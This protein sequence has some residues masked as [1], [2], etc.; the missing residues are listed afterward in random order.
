MTH[1]WLLVLVGVLTASCSIL[2]PLGRTVG[3]Y[4]RHTANT[5]DISPA[6]IDNNQKVDVEGGIAKLQ[7]WSDEFGS[8]L[9]GG[10]TVGVEY[11]QENGSVS[12][13]GGVCTV[14]AVGGGTDGAIRA[15]AIF[16]TSVYED[17]T[18]EADFQ[19]YDYSTTDPSAD[20]CV[21]L[22]LWV[23]TNNFAHIYMHKSS[24]SQRIYAV[25][26]VGGTYNTVG[27]IN[28]T[29]TD[30][31]F[32][33]VRSGDTISFHY[34]DGGG[35]LDSPEILVVDNDKVQWA[36]NAGEGKVW[37]LT[38]AS[39]AGSQPGTS[40]IKFKVGLGN[41]SERSSATWHD[42][43]KWKT[44]SEINAAAENGEFDRYKYI[45]VSTQFNSDGKD[46]PALTSFSIHGCTVH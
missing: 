13:T 15:K 40:S 34:D 23:D 42:E 25:K 39:A 8:S 37:K 9:D 43:G 20:G 4:E 17:V 24:S 22:R 7:L 44:I 1:H 31:K 3:K 14:S 46:Q 28:S 2:V 36:F 18:V 30:F 35:W 16:S 29:S 45:F 5:F 12:E 26:R 6:L 10:W 41:S 32:R 38:G 33:I 21:I 19:N 11:W 27:E